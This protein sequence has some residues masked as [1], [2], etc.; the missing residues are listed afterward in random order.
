LDVFEMHKCTLIKV[1]N[2]T[3]VIIQSSH[4]FYTIKTFNQLI[5]AKFIVIIFRNFD[6]NLRVTLSAT[7]RIFEHQNILLAIQFFKKDKDGKLVKDK[8]PITL[9]AGQT[10]YIASNRI[11]DAT[12][13]ED[14]KLV[15]VHSGG[16][17]F[18]GH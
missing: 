16:F 13:V 6:T 14:C 9:V 5:R 7:H 12:Y 17:G 4:G 2:S 11:H 3:K 15:Y 1:Y 10:G 18:D 8:E